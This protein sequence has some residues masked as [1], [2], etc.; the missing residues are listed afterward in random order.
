MANKGAITR[1]ELAP[2]GNEKLL[3]CGVE[4]AYRAKHVSPGFSLA[5]SDGN[6]SRCTDVKIR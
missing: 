1:P 3:K 6:Q 4:M 2:L 5:I